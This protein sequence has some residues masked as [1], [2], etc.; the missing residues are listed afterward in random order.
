[1]S[2]VD[3]AIT[4]TIGKISGKQWANKCRGVLK[5]VSPAVS[6]P[7]RIDTTSGYPQHTVASSAVGSVSWVATT[8]HKPEVQVSREKEKISE[9]SNFYISVEPTEE[10]L[11]A[12]AEEVVRRIKVA[13]SHNT[14]DVI[15][16]D[17]EFRILRE[18]AKSYLKNDDRRLPFIKRLHEA[19]NEDKSISKELRSKVYHSF[20]KIFSTMQICAQEIVCRLKEVVTFGELAAALREKKFIGYY[21][22]MRDYVQSCREQ[23]IDY[24]IKTVNEMSLEWEEEE[25]IYYA[26]DTLITDIDYSKDKGGDVHASSGASPKVRDQGRRRKSKKVHRS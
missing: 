1:M 23:F 9:C 26:V 8:L 2:R 11:P 18:M 19:V 17:I 4:Q 3:I 12:C 14:L 25:N 21:H 13:I 20:D 6:S 16:E 22:L 15:L 7:K 10:L 5:T 24:V